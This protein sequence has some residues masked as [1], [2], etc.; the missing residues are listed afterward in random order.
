MIQPEIKEIESLNLLIFD[1]IILS[2]GLPIY[3][4]N[5]GKQALIKVD[6][7]FDAGTSH[8]EDPVLPSAVN[9]LLNDGTSQYNSQEIASIIDGKGAFY[10]PDVH[11]DFSQMSLYLL[12]RFASDLLPLFIDMISDSIFPKE[13]LIIYKGSMKQRF[14]V[15]HEKVNVQSYQR[16]I[17][18]LFGKDSIYAENTKAEDYDNLMQDSIRKFYNENIR[19][20][21][22]S[23]I[24]SGLVDDKVK[25]EVISNFE[26]LT[27]NGKK[28]KEKEK[29]IV[30]GKTASTKDWIKIPGKDNNQVSLR[31]GTP[32]I[33]TD[34]KDFFGLS[35]L[36]TIVGGYFGSRLNKVIREEK[37]LTYGVHGHI[38][39]LKHAAFLGIH[40]EL[41]AANWEEAYD[42]IIEVFNDLKVNE[43]GTN[44][45][46]MVRRYIKGNLLQSIDG[47]FSFSSYLRNTIIYSMDVNRLNLY[48]NYLD[49]MQVGELNQLAKQ[50]LDENSFYKIVAG[51]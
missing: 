23:V 44:E 7:L 25:K 32:T 16:F 2:N 8:S 22:K 1:K 37:G 31:I 39:K 34:H 43:I 51:I 10:V 14:L 50:Y 40:A 47:A 19:N 21:V 38:T 12:N 4:I 17:N 11:K 5:A 24:V 18:A 41:N 6:V 20:N 46:E 15:E 27:I 49:S 35:L 26:K 42:A 28:G 36:T 33:K 45:L 30:Y 29:F 13:E 48:I 3:F 9:A